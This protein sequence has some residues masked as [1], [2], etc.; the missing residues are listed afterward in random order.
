[1]LRL[2]PP[3]FDLF[4]QLGGGKRSLDLR[5]TRNEP[6]LI[7]GTSPGLGCFPRWKLAGTFAA[8]SEDLSVPS[9]KK[10]GNEFLVVSLFGLLT[11]MTPN[12]AHM[13]PISPPL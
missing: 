6:E 1:M 7:H 4:A 3:G 12:G 9:R 11:T 13:T 10:N 8:G 5:T 2:K